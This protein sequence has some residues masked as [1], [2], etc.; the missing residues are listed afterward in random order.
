VKPKV[1]VLGFTVE[2]IDYVKDMVK[3]KH[4]LKNIDNND[5]LERAEKYDPR[6]RDVTIIL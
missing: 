6:N 1:K 4:S 2:Y 5:Y 3:F